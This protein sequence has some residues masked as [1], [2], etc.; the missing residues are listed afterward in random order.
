[1]TWPPDEISGNLGNGGQDTRPDP[2][3]AAAVRPVVVNQRQ[4]PPALRA[5]SLPVAVGLSS[6]MGLPL[7]LAAL[8]ATIALTLAPASAGKFK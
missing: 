5:R 7:G 8:L 6:E 1:M 4:W 3:S 2:C